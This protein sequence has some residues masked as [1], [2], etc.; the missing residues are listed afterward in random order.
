MTLTFFF[1]LFQTEK[2]LTVAEALLDCGS[3]ARGTL[4]PSGFKK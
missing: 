1:E 3:L 4:T 2:L